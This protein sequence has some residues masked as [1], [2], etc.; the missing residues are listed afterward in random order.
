MILCITYTYMVGAQGGPPRG[1]NS[2]G[3]RRGR[4]A[5]VGGLCGS[6]P[7]RRRHR[8]LSQTQHGAPARPGAGAALSAPHRNH[9]IIIIIIITSSSSAGGRFD[10]THRRRR[11][12]AQ[13]VTSHTHIQGHTHIHIQRR[14]QRLGVPAASARHCRA[15]LTAEIPSL[16]SQL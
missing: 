7:R 16:T 1:H 8:R 5:G 11:S 13:A 10:H 4:Q 6:L 12:A 15:P 14:T 9:I 2:V 3:L